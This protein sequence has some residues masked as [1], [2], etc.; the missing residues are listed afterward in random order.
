M[1]SYTEPV[2]TT[3]TYASGRLT[4]FEEDPILPSSIVSVLLRSIQSHFISADRIRNPN[5]QALLWTSNITSTA[6]VIGPGTAI[7]DLE[8]MK[9]PQVRLMRAPVKPIALNLD[10]HVASLS[11]IVAGRTN[12]SGATYQRM[13]SGAIMVAAVC[14]Q[15]QET[16]FLAEE[17]LFLLHPL[18][19]MLREDAGMRMFEAGQLEQVT[20][21]EKG[22]FAVTF[23]LNYAVDWTFRIP[24]EDVW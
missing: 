9:K 22:G 5:L 11:I 17:L 15:S 3:P 2:W 1:A 23:P 20:A 8:A 10:P 12:S 18:T 16:E 19:L 7:S 4:I 6:I 14:E 24:E 13:L 21:L